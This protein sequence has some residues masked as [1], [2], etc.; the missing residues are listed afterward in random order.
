VTDKVRPLVLA[1]WRATLVATLVAAAAVSLLWP[2]R[3]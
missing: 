3:G 2:A 1:G